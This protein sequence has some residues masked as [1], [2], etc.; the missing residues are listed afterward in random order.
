[1]KNTVPLLIV[2]ILALVGYI[3]YTQFFSE[4]PCVVRHQLNSE[5]ANLRKQAIAEGAYPEPR[6]LAGTTANPKFIPETIFV[7]VGEGEFD[8]EEKPNPAYR[9][10]KRTAKTDMYD[11]KI[12]ELFLKQQR[13]NYACRRSL[14]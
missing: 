10:F 6:Y 2:I 12:D 8:I 14:K 11:K 3:A 1:M 9:P 4:D 7:R 5:M 13:A